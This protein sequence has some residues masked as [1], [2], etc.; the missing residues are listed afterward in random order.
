MIKANFKQ[1]FYKTI[2]QLADKHN[3]PIDKVVDMYYEQFN[4]MAQ[5][6]RNDK[7]SIKIRGLGTFEYKEKLAE[8]LAILKKLKNE[9]EILLKAST[10]N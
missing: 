8:K 10:E 2:Q 9:R 6:V 7:A 1:K 5:S 3:L 4:L